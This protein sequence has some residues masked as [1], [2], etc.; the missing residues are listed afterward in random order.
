ML[1]QFFFLICGLGILLAGGELLV[2][3]ASGLAKRYGVPAHIIGLTV[4]A[5]GT[6]APELFV[7]GMAAYRESSEISFGNVIGSNISNLGLILGICALIRPLLI[8]S[9]I[10]T[11]EIPMLLLTSL[12]AFILGFDPVLRSSAS[13]YDRSDGLILLLLF[14]IFIYYT[15]FDVIRQKDSD[16]MLSQG[17]DVIEVRTAGNRSLVNILLFL[18]GLTLLILGGDLSVKSAI[19]V[20]EHFHVPK[21]IIGLTI[22]AIGTSLP[23]LVTSAIAAW[24][25]QTDIAIGNLVGSNIFNLLFIMGISATIHPVVI[26]EIGGFYDLGIM[27]F[28]A[29]LLLPLAITDNRKV[30]RWEGGVLL[31]IYCIYNIWRI[32]I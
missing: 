25:G 15:V 31:A 32:S 21:E 23:E 9:V 26:P 16:P 5:F 19:N 1:Q 4:V 18:G 29:V 11:R 3:G 30:V 14:C 6:S 13:V 7:N 27:L 2:R 24:K 17:D 22:I 20:A 28:L 12:T 8:E 10:L